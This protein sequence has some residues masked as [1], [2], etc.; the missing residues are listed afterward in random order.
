MKVESHQLFSQA[1][2][3][4]TAGKILQFPLIR[5]VLVLLFIGPYLLLHNNLTE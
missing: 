4:S 2:P 5:I 1:V 3:K